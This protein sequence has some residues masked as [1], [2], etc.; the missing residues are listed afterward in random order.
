MHAHGELR[1]ALQKT[2]S[3][4]RKSVSGQK[5]RLFAPIQIPFAN[6]PQTALKSAKTL[7]HRKNQPITIPL[8][9]KWMV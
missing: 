9:G 2:V 5:I 7:T 4:G 1:A 8:D 6:N 3:S